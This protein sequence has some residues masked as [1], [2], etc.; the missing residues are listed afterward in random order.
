MSPPLHLKAGDATVH[1]VLVGHGASE[2]Q[3]DEPRWAYICAYIPGDALYTGAPNY[4][5]DG[6]G[7][8][9]NKPIDHPR[10]PILYP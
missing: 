9:V 10:F 6:I 2:N 1:S 3:T 7:L 8:E 5:Y 4:N